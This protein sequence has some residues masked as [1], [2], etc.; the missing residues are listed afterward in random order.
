MKTAGLETFDAV[1]K[2]LEPLREKG[3]LTTLK[4]GEVMT[5]GPVTVIGTG[6]NPLH[7]VA[8]VPDRDYF[9][10]APLANLDDPEYSD[11]NGLISPIASTDFASAVGDITVD[12]DPIL[13][14]KQLKV[15]R[16]QIA[17]ATKRGIGA[18]YW[19]TPYFP[20]RKRNLVWRTLLREG[21]TLLNADDL[22]AVVANF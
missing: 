2:A 9:F 15:L 19:N 14:D 21:V 6:E 7:R 17:T 13:T 22:D 20:I 16:N 3:Y 4:D 11:V 1:I 5:Y 8:S 12:T 18:R 10:D